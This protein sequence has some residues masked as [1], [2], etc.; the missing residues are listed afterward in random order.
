[1]LWVDEI[2]MVLLNFILSFECCVPCA[3]CRVPEQQI[4]VNAL[5]FNSH[6]QCTDSVEQNVL[7]R[8]EIQ[9]AMTEVYR[10]N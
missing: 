8:P 2:N 9:N 4:F 6:V 5:Q 10:Y 1:M 7:H 3:V